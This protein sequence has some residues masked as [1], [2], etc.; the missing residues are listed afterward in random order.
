[1]L[2]T[3]VPHPILISFFDAHSMLQNDENSQPAPSI[4]PAPSEWWSIKNLNDRIAE[5]EEE[6]ASLPCPKEHEKLKQTLTSV[7]TEHQQ[8]R[9]RYERE[10]QQMQ[11]EL[12]Q[13][14]KAVRDHEE[15]ADEAEYRG[16]QVTKITKRLHEYRERHRTEM[17]K[18]YVD[19]ENAHFELENA[20]HDN[21]NL[22]EQV[23]LYQSKVEQV[24]RHIGI[25]QEVCAEI[26]PTLD[27]CQTEIVN[28][29]VGQL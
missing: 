14:R 28:R 18:M 16:H 10:Q 13:M 21:R 2:E 25:Y 15:T 29:I 26:I 22:K 27:E 8:H 3:G 19:L 5:L 7:T 20:Q 6:R 24:E 17:D 1:M 23:S 9:E 12:K 11:Q 4:P